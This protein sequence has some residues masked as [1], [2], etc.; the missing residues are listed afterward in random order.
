V[1]VHYTDLGGTT[2]V[3]ELAVAADGTI[4]ADSRRK[5]LSQQQPFAN[6]NG[7]SLLFGPDGLLYLALGDGGS[8][9]DPQRNGLDLSTWLG[10]ILRIDPTASGGEGYTVPTD[11]PFVG[12][13]GAR[14]EIWSYGLR[15]PWRVSF[16]IATGDVWIADVG[17][18]SLEEVNRSPAAAGAGRGINFGWSAFEGTQRFND[19]QDPNGAIGPVFE[20][21]HGPEACSITGGYVYRGEAIPALRGAYVFAD[22]CGSGVF[23]FDPADPFAGRKL[24][25]EPGE[26]VS[27][28]VDQAN[29]LY[30]LSFDGSVYRVD[31]A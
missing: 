30:V 29:E 15:N 25:D 23:A 26:V 17:Q 2:Q 18:G 11:N 28:G 4:D 21:A 12:Q 6:H 14:P 16:D 27:F 31:P 19:D 24:L 3:D 5:V 13:G 7:G 1:Y 9:G 20:Y 8:G 10:K 22:Y